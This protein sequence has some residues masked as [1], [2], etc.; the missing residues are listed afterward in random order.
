MIETRSAAKD[1]LQF[2]TDWRQT[3]DEYDP[4]TYKRRVI[5][6]GTDFELSTNLYGY[7]MT[8]RIVPFEVNA[9]ATLLW[10]DW[11]ATVTAARRLIAERAAQEASA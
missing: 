9:H 5:I 4:S 7:G 11:P 8:L 10:E 3:F 2:R 1:A 6:D